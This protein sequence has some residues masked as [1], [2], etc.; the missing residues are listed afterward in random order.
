MR[1]D[2]VS[3]RK[4]G[5]R[6][7]RLVLLAVALA[8]WWLGDYVLRPWIEDLTGYRA[9]ANR[10]VAVLVGH[11]LV[12]QLPTVI[13]CVAIWVV[14]ARLEFMPPLRG[15]LGSGGSWRRVLVSGLL[16]TAI[17]LALTLGLSGAFGARYGWH[18][19]GTKMAGDLASNLYEELVF[20]GLIFSAFYGAA[21]G[22]TFPLAGRLDRLGLVA[23]TIGSCLFFGLAHEQYPLPARITV[24]V[25]SILFVWPWVR[26]RSLWAP[27][28]PHM[29]GDIIGDSVLRL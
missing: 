9:I 21:A 8:A 4:I 11:W 22:S 2:P 17:V 28:I 10:D 16:A 18:P 26:A 3:S 19:D 20:R 29:L 5:N 6:L 24:G 13:L 23:G 1:P 7:P 15:A 27:W 25:G 12:W 14:A